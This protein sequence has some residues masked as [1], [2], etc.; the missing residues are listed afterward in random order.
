MSDIRNWF[1]PQ[2]PQASKPPIKIN[3]P[4]HEPKIDTEPGVETREIIVYT[5]G[6]A[7]N[8]GSFKATGGSG[9]F[10]GDGDPRNISKKILQGS[11]SAENKVTNN[12][13]EL[14][15][16][17]LAI[18]KIVETE[19]TT[20]GLRIVIFTDSEYI[21]K[22]VLQYSKAWEKNGYKN[23][24][25]QPIKN[26]ALMKRVIEL[27]KKY[28]VKLHHCMAHKSEPKDPIKRKVWCGNKMADYLARK[29]SV[30]E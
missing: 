25:G 27:Y 21:V 26:M 1:A 6:S 3:T 24:K 2:A 13:C 19:S 8:N 11:G 30:P 28:N 20:V 14:F 29:A 18:E 10:F 17:K 7:I 5:D 15:A 9:V 4:E 12:I 16:V 22:S 23:K